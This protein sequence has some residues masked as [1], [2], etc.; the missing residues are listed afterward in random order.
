MTGSKHELKLPRRF[1]PLERL[2]KGGGGEVWAVR[3]RPSGERFALKV[4]AADAT[5]HEMAAL[6]RE[7]V[8]LSGL[9]GLGVPRVIRFGRLPESRRPFLVRELVE[10][11]SLEDVIEEGSDLSGTLEA[12][13]TAAE[14]VTVL[15]RA[16]FLHGDIKPANIIVQE[17]GSGTLVD[18]GLAAMWQEEGTKAEGL[19]PKY[20]APE[21]FEGKPLTV[22][23]EVYALGVALSDAVN[24]TREKVSRALEKELRAV[25][26]RATC[27]A[28][29][30]RFPSA[31]EFAVAL[32]HAAKLTDHRRHGGVV[33]P[34]VGIDSTAAAL[35]D[36]VAALD[37]GGALVIDG[38]SG[39]GRSALLRRLAWSLGVEGRP[40]AWVDESSVKD[41][42][43]VEAELDGHPELSGV[44]VLV[45]DPGSLGEESS[46]RIADAVSA[47]ARVVTVGAAPF[48]R[49]AAR[50]VVPPLDEHACIELVRRTV[51]SLTERLLQRVVR[52]SAGRPGALRQFVEKLATTAVASEDDLDRILGAQSVGESLVPSDPLERAGYYLDRGRFID[53]R[54]ALD[55]VDGGDPLVVATARARLEA[56]QGNAQATLDVLKSVEAEAE[57]RRDLQEGKLWLLYYGRVHIFT[58][59]YDKAVELLRTIDEEPG[60]IGAEARAVIGLAL[61][62][63][64]KPEEARRELEAAVELA[65]KCNSPRVEGVALGSLGFALQRDDRFEE[66]RAAYDQAIDAAERASDA[67]TLAT[68]QLNRAGLLKVSGDI[69]R[70]IEGFEAAADMGRRAG[71]FSTVRQA[72]L[73]LANTDLYLGRLGRARS[74]IEALDDERESLSRVTR[75][76]LT[77]LQAELAGRTKELER[78]R[79]L[80]EAC[81]AEY[82]ALGQRVDAAEA[83][84]EG[85]LVSMRA[86]PRDVARARRQIEIATEELGEA[87]AHRPLLLLATARVTWVAGD[88][89]RAR[90]EL[91]RALGAAREGQHREWVWRTLESRAEL[92]EAAGQTMTARRDREEALTVLE[93]IGARLPRDLREVYWNHPRRRAL[94]A[95][96]QNHVESAAT[97]FAPQFPLAPLVSRAS[98][99]SN[100]APLS[101]ETPLEQ[102]LARILEVNSVLAGEHDLDRLTA[103]VTDYAVS[104]LGAER[105]FVLLLQPDATLSVHTSRYLGAEDAGAEFSR[106]IARQVLDSGE[107]VASTSPGDDSRLRSFQSVHQLMLK[108]VACVPITS[109]TGQPIGGLYVETRVRPGVNFQRELPTLAA[110]ADQVAIAIHNAQLIGENVR[111]AEQLEKTNAELEEAQGRLR[112]L[113]SNR[114][115]KLNRTRRKLRDAQDTI[116]AHFGYHGLVGMS[117]AM[118]RV[119]ALIDRVKD[120]DVP[121]LIT[122]ESGTGKEVVAQAIHRA[123]ERR[124]QAFLGVN[125]G[126]IP[127]H[128][129]ESELFGHVKGAFT[130][131]DRERKGLFREGQGGTLL[132][133][134]IGEMPHKMQAG[135]LRVL[136]ER[137]VRPVGGAREE[138]VDVHTIFA[139]NRDLSKM[140]EEKTFREDLYYR[141]HVVEVALPALRER[142]EDIAPL[143]DHFLGI[144]AAKYKR[145]RKTVTR[146]GMRRLTAFNWPGNVRQL[147]HVLLNAWVLSDQAELDIDDFDMP[148]GYASRPPASGP[149]KTRQT[150]SEPSSHR[151]PKST[152]SQHRNEEREQIL[153]ALQTCNWNRV[154]AAELIGLPRRTFYRRLR[155]Y[156][157]Q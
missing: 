74:S 1:E 43:A 32:R 127:E 46:K 70:S 108:A 152:L 48:A 5:E 45:D 59:E 50:F 51:P 66:A 113:L 143:V 124:S 101:L 63:L 148:D 55:A 96:V 147:E 62:L 86:P 36:R 132:L 114:T 19:T 87:P 146:D 85:V 122:G 89:D 3:E 14:Q 139:T 10:G 18:L 30:E 80:Y 131:A 71:R 35:L 25:T 149:P 67:S 77:G 94:R 15:H 20:A 82:V 88:E 44:A 29:A 81:A 140:V 83:R 115:A 105:G 27:E 39:S 133:D 57:A 7:A 28:P 116:N 157:I 102:R 41:E 121:V 123:A 151:V 153:R 155:E 104:L 142:T 26:E 145:E 16:G 42:S 78:A 125:C 97:Q 73:N 130:G 37:P 91:E 61:S 98:S 54:T 93:E 56:G 156:G 150:R 128:L 40:L 117:S 33:W 141:I 2:G 65:R 135:L 21:L 111:R 47:G 52:A 107:P 58:G 99:T 137:T 31:D 75:A 136:Q 12:L 22:R 34:I 64:G 9:E 95:G 100:T 13:A 110:F 60:Q 68:T 53:A 84:L 69:A 8:A 126:A 106:S 4:L 138:A 90:E 112:E 120:T 23:A 103:K 79:E 6:V 38:P 109:P 154:K 129:L 118:R 134:E 72:L 11:R 92:E 144:F 17:D 76:Q 24:K 119:Y 49:D